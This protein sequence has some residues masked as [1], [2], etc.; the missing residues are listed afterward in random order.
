MYI[1]MSMLMYMPKCSTTVHSKSAT[2]VD[3]EVSLLCLMVYAEYISASTAKQPTEKELINR[4]HH[5]LMRD[6]GTVVHRLWRWLWLL[7]W[8]VHT[9]GGHVRLRHCRRIEH[10]CWCSCTGHVATDITTT[11]CHQKTSHQQHC[12]HPAA[13]KYR[14]D[15]TGFVFAVSFPFKFF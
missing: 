8:K 6:V 5:L 1:S 11:P 9:G 2:R 12:K 3:N 10:W 7:C 4:L 13:R 14:T 15:F